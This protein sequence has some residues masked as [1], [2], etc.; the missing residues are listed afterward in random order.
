[1][2]VDKSDNASV[3]AMSASARGLHSSSITSRLSQPPVGY[4]RLLTVLTIFASKY[5]AAWSCV[6]IIVRG[7]FLTLTWYPHMFRNVKDLQNRNLLT[8]TSLI[9][10]KCLCLLIGALRLIR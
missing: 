1:M 3:V 9:V 10:L 6:S 8:R 7:Y 5:N 2:A 4:Q